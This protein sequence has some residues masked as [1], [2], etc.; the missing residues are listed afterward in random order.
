MGP[1]CSVFSQRQT[2]KPLGVEVVMVNEGREVVFVFD[3]KCE[4]KDCSLKV[5]ALADGSGLAAEI[6]GT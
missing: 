3:G 2:L 1:N 6:S 5:V 4:K